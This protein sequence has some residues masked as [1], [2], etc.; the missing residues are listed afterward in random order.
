MSSEKSAAQTIDEYIS[1]FPPDVQ[2]L[3]EQVRLAIRETAPEAQ[4]TISYAIPTFKPNGRYLVYFAAFKQH[5]SLYPAPIGVAE[6]NEAVSRYGSGKGTLKFPLNQPLP[7]D[8]VR[9][10]VQ[11]RL[12]EHSEHSLAKRKK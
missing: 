2:A 1:A 8:L 11:Y 5:I 4:E 6:F 9:S 12:R 7:L 3:L 10:V